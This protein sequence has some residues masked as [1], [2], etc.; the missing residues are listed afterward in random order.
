MHQAE[1]RK[2]A[3]RPED[4]ERWDPSFRP[5]AADTAEFARVKETD[6]FHPLA[7]CNHQENSFHD[8]GAA[9]E[10]ADVM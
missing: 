7:S 4:A 3:N 1:K 10:F 6:Y 9:G 5:P 2:A 8:G